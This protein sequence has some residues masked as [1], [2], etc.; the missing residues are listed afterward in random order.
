MSLVLARIDDRLVHGQ[1]VLVWGQ[2]LSATRLLVADDEVASHPWERDLMG[3]TA[4]GMEVEVVSLGEV[5]TRLEEER[6]RPGATILLLRSAAAARAVVAAGATLEEINLGGLHY[7]AGKEKIFDYLYL[8]EA[9]NAALRDLQMR[10]VR[11]MAQDVPASRAIEAREF[12][13]GGESR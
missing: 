5:P 13:S 9:D 2:A 4:E 8:S 7:A 3:T 10:G 1:V 6:E 11:M 12:L